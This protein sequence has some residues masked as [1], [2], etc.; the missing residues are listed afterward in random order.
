MVASIASILS[1]DAADRRPQQV[2]RRRLFRKAR[3]ARG[4]TLVKRPAF[5][6]QR[7]IEFGG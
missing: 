6:G 4:T 5:F 3:T 1:I 7:S 2:V